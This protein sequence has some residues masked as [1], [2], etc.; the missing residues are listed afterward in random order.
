MK[1][2][3]GIALLILVNLAFIYLLIV[4][5]RLSF[6]LIVADLGHERAIV[7]ANETSKEIY[8]K[9]CIVSSLVFLIN[10]F[11]SK[12]VIG[13]RNPLIKSILITFIGIIVF[14]P[15]F[16]S[17]RISFVNDQ[18]EV[19]FLSHYLDEKSISSIQ[20]IRHSDTIEIEQLDNFIKDISGA[21][22]M[23]GMWKYMKNTKIL[24]NRTNGTKD[25]VL[26]NGQMFGGYKGKFFETDVNVI[27]KYLEEK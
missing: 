1:R 13:M 16:V 21:K 10:Y 24:F 19:T 11:L 27:D 20:V 25:T 3:L 9:L 15:F 7:V 12:K 4:L 14:V 5:A 18:D 23:P 26:T 2:K 17:S 22:Y 8:L 6:G